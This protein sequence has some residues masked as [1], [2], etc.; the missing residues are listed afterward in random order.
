M[1]DAIADGRLPVGSRLP[2]TRTLGAE[3][4]VSRGMVTEAYQR[5]VED[6]H[7]AGRGRAGTVVVAV[8]VAAS[9]SPPR[10]PEDVGFE[11]HP[12]VFD[13]L[14]AAPARID[15]TPGVPDL[16]A[17]PRAVWLRAER[18]V[19]NNLSAPDFGYGDPRGAPSFRLAVAN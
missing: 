2:A 13:R 16:A 19:L 7:V 5:L 6:G 15:L 18:A 14:R 8:P 12:D 10:A 4:G 9:P 17:F 3:L 1:R 11:P